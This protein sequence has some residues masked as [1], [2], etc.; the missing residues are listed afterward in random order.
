MLTYTQTQA[1]MHAYTH[2]ASGA[3]GRRKLPGS[4]TFPYPHPG[5]D[6]AAVCTGTW[7][8]EKGGSRVFR[9]GGGGSKQKEAQKIW[10]S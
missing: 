10:E 9:P 8:R 3:E 6:W 7:D 1:C 2:A 5:L 4:V